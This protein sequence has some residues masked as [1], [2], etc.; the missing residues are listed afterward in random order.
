MERIGIEPMTSCLQ[1][2]R[3]A[4]I[5]GNDWILGSRTE[6]LQPLSHDDVSVVRDH[7]RR[8]YGCTYKACKYLRAHRGSLFRNNA[9]SPNGSHPEKLSGFLRELGG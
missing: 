4:Q 8:L 6:A 9:S 1:S 7:R 5:T 3:P 2:R